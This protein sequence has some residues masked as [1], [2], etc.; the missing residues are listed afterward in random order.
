MF[1]GQVVPRNTGRDP[2]IHQIDLKFLHEVTFL[3]RHRV[4]FSV[5]ILK[6]GNMINSN[7]GL[8]RRTNN[9]NF[10][11]LEARHLP[12]RTGE[13]NGIFVY[14][15]LDSLLDEDRVTSTTQL[16]SRWSIPMGVKYRF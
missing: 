7:W 13:T 10:P 6:I 12:D 14:R 1:Q 5:A 11:L 15:F 9:G 3:K 4:E 2:W 16:S 8:V